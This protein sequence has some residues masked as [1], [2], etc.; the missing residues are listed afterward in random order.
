MAFFAGI[1]MKTKEV[2]TDMKEASKRKGK[3]LKEDFTKKSERR[4]KPG[5]IVIVLATVAILLVAIVWS[6]QNQSIYRTIVRNGYTGTQEQMLASLVGEEAD[7]DVESAYTLAVNNG[8]KGTLADWS[9][10]FVGVPVEFTGVSTYRQAC[11]NGFEGSLTEWLTQIASNP[12]KL[13]RS[14]NG[15]QKTEYELACEYGYIGTFI[16]WLVSVTQDRVLN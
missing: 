7:S 14:G 12:E 6:T 2:R 3:Y 1:L 5:V 15:Q 4:V 11:E 16:E 9:E 10:T 13:G 8:Y